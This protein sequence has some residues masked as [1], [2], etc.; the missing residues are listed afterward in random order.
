M[1]LYSANTVLYIQCTVLFILYQI[2]TY[3]VYK[4]IK[5]KSEKCTTLGM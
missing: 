1:A 4:N 5:R 2:S 3:P